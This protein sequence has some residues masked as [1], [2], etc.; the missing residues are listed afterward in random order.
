MPSSRGELG[1]HLEVHHVAGVVLDDVEHAG[2]A[3]D[4]LGG[5]QHLVGRGRGEDRA[6]AGRVEHAPADE[7]AV[8]GLVARAAARDERHLALHR[9]V[10]A[11]DEVGA[12]RHSQP[13][14]MGPREA[15]ELLRSRRLRAG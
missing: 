2:A 12:T 14:G 3:V 1:G 15:L 5:G 8:H 6:R 10:G 13:V 7:A 9:R 4:R 11:H